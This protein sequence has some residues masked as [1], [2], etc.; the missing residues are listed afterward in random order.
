[1]ETKVAVAVLC[2][3]AAGIVA[4]WLAWRFRAPAIL[5]LF[6]I[7]LVFGPGLGLLHPSQTVGPA[8]RPL[9]GLAVGIVVFEGGLS[10]NVRELRAAGEGVL[11]L[12]TIALPLNWGL[13]ALAA[14]WIG[15]FG[16]G[17]AI[18]FGAITVVTGPTVVLPL[19]RHVRL[20]RRAAS[21]LRWEAIVNDPIGAILAVVMLETLTG[22]GDPWMLASKVAAGLAA[23]CALGI[24]SA[25][26]VRWSFSRDL[27]PEFLKRPV[28]LAFVLS[29]Y[30]VANLAL[31][32]AGLMAATIFGMAVANLGITGAAE[33]RRFKE[34][35]VVLL[36]SALFVVLTAD[37]D[38]AM[39]AQLDWRLGALTA[40]MLFLVR[41]AAILLATL[42]SGLSWQERFLCGWIAPRGIVAAAMAGVAGLRLEHA[43][44]AG[45][46]LVMPAVFALIAATM[47][48]HGFSLGPIARRLGLQLGQGLGL[49]IVG[50]SRWA[51]DL[52]SA[53][54]QAGLEV[55]LADTY[56]GALNT[57]RKRGVP[58]L[59]AEILSEHGAEALE[60][61][62]V[63]Y[64]LAATPDNIYN[65]LVCTRLAPELGLE[66]VFQLA[67]S[68]AEI[69]PH[70]GLTREWR[71]KVLANFGLSYEALEERWKSGWRFGV[72]DIE[73][74]P[75]A[76]ET[77]PLMLLHKNG[78][79][80]IP[81]PEHPCAL[82]PTPGERMILMAP[83]TPSQSV[84]SAAAEAY[85]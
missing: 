28:L 59:Q 38:R 65:G 2:I 21:F 18:L 43:G 60:T 1:M 76:G 75:P 79:I 64:V 54:H 19:L 78:Q 12:T 57:A 77:V 49:L 40:A 6:A 63:D 46:G 22:A 17:A 16:W 66:R 37:L 11:R 10:L 85:P 23:A 39:L 13:S 27:V 72:A 7:G 9:V 74:E 51:T 58:V 69:D 82:M 5:L 42:R 31:A 50:A 3:A 80:T 8:L 41:P 34:A 32:E 84:A 55:T 53:L 4:Q 36:V 26:F 52:A 45:G 67:P 81:S 68:K 15:G 33:L 73:G 35:V 44:Y 24:G 30:A 70:K 47:I 14:H 29:I 20:E 71:G 25:L 83:P 61:R 62:P 56:P 48:L